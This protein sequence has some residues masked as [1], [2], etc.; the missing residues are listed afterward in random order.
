MRKT[1]NFLNSMGQS[2]RRWK[3][4]KIEI[5]LKKQEKSQ[6][7]L[8]SNGIRKKRKNKSKSQQEE[9]NNKNHRR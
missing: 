5:Y 2:K 4:K 6:P 3:F 7:N 8:L 9:G 1:H